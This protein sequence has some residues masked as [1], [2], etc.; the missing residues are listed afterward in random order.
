MLLLITEIPDEVETAELVFPA[1]S[2][3]QPV[4]VRESAAPPA[5]PTRVEKA[6]EKLQPDIV[7][8]P[9]VIETLEFT[10][11][12]FSTPPVKTQA[13]AATRPADITMP[14]NV[15]KSVFET[16]QIVSPGKPPV[17]DTGPTVWLVET[18]QT[19]P[20]PLTIVVFAVTPLPVT[21]I[22]TYRAPVTLLTI[23]VVP[24]IVP[25]KYAPVPAPLYVYSC[26]LLMNIEFEMCSTSQRPLEIPVLDM[27]AK[28]AAVA[29]RELNEPWLTL[30]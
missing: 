10:V 29:A 6:L 20:P 25:V 1:I 27:D 30:S 16:S 21:V 4:I 28:P 23:I 2:K 7:N 12:L 17:I 14:L 13:E 8:L 15:S 24:E 9:P 19:E 5:Y 26:V 18:T 3:L 11:V 22:P